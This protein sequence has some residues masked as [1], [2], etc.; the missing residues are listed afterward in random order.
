MNAFGQQTCDETISGLHHFASS[1]LEV[2]NVSR[3][4]ARRVFLT[5]RA[6]I[7]PGRLP[8]HFFKVV[9]GKGAIAV[10]EV[11]GLRATPVPVPGFR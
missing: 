9:E 10:E 6:E 4:G 5:N 1:R 8:H 11:G 3:H 7:N 2:G